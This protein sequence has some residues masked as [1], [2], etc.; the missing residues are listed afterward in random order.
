MT[1]AVANA[2]YRTFKPVAEVIEVGAKPQV[3]T[4]Q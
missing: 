1:D 3:K 4:L 2:K